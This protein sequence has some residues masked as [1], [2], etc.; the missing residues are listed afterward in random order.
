MGLSKVMLLHHIFHFPGI[1]LPCEPSKE[2]CVQIIDLF[3]S[4]L[5]KMVRFNM[6]FKR[7]HGF[8]LTS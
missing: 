4:F 3:I 2:V 7:L 8:S 1:D 6:V 5:E